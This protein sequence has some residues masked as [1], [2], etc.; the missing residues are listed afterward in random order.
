VN[1]DNIIDIYAV[2][3]GK[4]KDGF[5]V[6]A[7]DAQGRYHEIF[8][9]V[10]KGTYKKE[11]LF[12]YEEFKCLI[13]ALF[14]RH[15]YQTYGCLREYNFN[16]VDDVLAPKTVSD[17]YFE[18]LLKELQSLEKPLVV[19]SCIEDILRDF[20]SNKR[21]KRKII[22]IGPATLRRAF[23]KMTDEEKDVCF[24]KMRE[25]IFGKQ[26]EV[27]GEGFVKPSVLTDLVQVTE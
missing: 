19:Q 10:I 26:E 7:D 2:T 20:D 18:L 23:A 11:S 12:S 13:S 17:M 1:R 27:V 24:A 21:R 5:D 4:Y 3:N 6:K 9:Y 16:V 14:N 15:V 25:A 8:K 22:Y